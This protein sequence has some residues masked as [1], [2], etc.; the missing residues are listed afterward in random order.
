LRIKRGDFVSFIGPSG[1]GKTSLLRV[2]ADLERR[3]SGTLKVNGTD[4]EDA[5]LNRLYWYV[6]QAP[7][8][9]PW[10]YIEQN[11]ALP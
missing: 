5:R 3:T 6:F 7:A 9:L 4:A 11:C 8:L 1:C 2:I 10:R